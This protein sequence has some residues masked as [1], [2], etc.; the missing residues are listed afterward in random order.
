LQ[1][2]QGSKPELLVQAGSENLGWDLQELV[3]SPNLDSS[4][5]P[6]LDWD[7]SCRFLL[8]DLDLLPDYPAPAAL[9]AQSV[10]PAGMYCY[11]QECLDCHYQ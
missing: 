7:H 9:P 3:S 8:P 10:E 1:L 5:T 2:L 11:Y 6:T 4:L